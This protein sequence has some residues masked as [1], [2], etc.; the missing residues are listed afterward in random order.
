MVAKSDQ[1]KTIQ[2]YKLDFAH[3]KSEIHLLERNDFAILKQ[4]N[5]RISGD[6]EKLKQ[7]M[8]EDLQRMQASIRLDMNLEKARVRDEQSVVQMKIKETESRLEQEVTQLR[9]NI[10]NVRWDTIKTIGGMFFLE[11]VIALIPFL[12]AATSIGFVILG[13]ARYFK[14]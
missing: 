6:V 10:E 2:G 3:L 5:E 4:E 8:R 11:S 14:S 12:A 7:K 1:A 9:A 13:W